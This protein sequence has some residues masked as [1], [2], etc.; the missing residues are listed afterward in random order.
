MSNYITVG[1]LTASQAAATLGTKTTEEKKE[2]T[3]SD[4][5]KM[6]LENYYRGKIS[7]QDMEAQ[8]RALA[9]QRQQQQGMGQYMPLLMI[10]GAVLLVV[11]L[12]RR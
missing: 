12:M 1:A 3:W 2:A 10:G 6:I 9:M 7:K 11:L 5:A 4:A 8:Q